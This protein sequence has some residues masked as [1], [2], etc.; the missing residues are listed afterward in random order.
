MAHWTKAFKRYERHFLLGLVIVLLATFSV[1]GA[2]T[3]CAGSMPPTVESELGGSFQLV[4]EPG[5]VAISDEDMQRLL[6]IF[7]QYM[8][9]VRMP[10]IDYASY[11]RGSQSP[12]MR[13]VAWMHALLARAS[14][15]AGYRCGPAQLGRAI[16]SV[17][18]S[19][20]RTASLEVTPEAY[21]RFI[22]QVW[23]RSPADFE[24]VVRGVVLKDELLSCLVDP[25]RF[26]QTYAQAYEDWKASRERVD[27]RYLAVEA[28]SFADEVRA[29][30]STRRALAEAEQPLRSVVETVRRLRLAL[31]RARDYKDAKGEWPATLA[32]LAAKDVQNQR[33][34]LAENLVRDPWG[35]D[36][37]YT[38]G[39]G[40]PVL[41][42]H[43]PDGKEGTADDVGLDMQAQLE[44]H[45]AVGR[46]AEALVRWRSAG[47]PRAWPGSLEDLVRAPA[48]AAGGAAMP[49][50]SSVPQD[51]W[52][53]PLS[54]VLGTG[55]ASGDEP[56]RLASA[57]PDGVAGT[58]DDIVAV[59]T[60]ERGRV[61][62]GPV[63]A[64]YLPAGRT[65][66]W[67]RAVTVSLANAEQGVYEASSVG[68]DGQPGTA[69]DLRGGNASDLEAFYAQPAVR[70]AFQQPM[71]RRFEALVMHLPLVSEAT[72]KRLWEDCPEQRVGPQDEQALFDRWQSGRGT[73]GSGYEFTAKDPRDPQDGHGMDLARK[74]GWPAQAVVRVPS[75]DCFPGLAAPPAPAE[76]AAPD[77]L[78]KEYEEQGWRE[79]LVRQEFLERVLNH[80]WKAVVAS[81][82]AIKAWEATAATSMAPRP[83]D[84]VTLVD[85]LSEERLGKYQP[86]EAERARGH[87]FL[88]YYTT[89]KADKTAVSLTRAEISAV[90]GLDELPLYLG[91]QRDGDVA[92]I[93]IQLN[94]RLTKVVAR[95][96]QLTAERIP[97]LAEV[98]DQ[99]FERWLERRQLDR[100]ERELAAFQRD[101]LQAPVVAE[102]QADT[103]WEAALEAWKKARPG[104]VVH[105]ERTGLFIGSSVPTQAR[106]APGASALEQAQ[107]LRRNFV[108]QGGYGLVRRGEAK[109]DTTDASPG[110]FGRATLRDEK[111]APDGT[112]CAF[113]VRVAERVYPTKAEFSPRAYSEYMS[114]RVFGAQRD[115]P[116]GM[117]MPV[118][119]RDG[120]MN[121]K[122]A[123][124]LEEFE[125]LQPLF[126]LR[127]NTNLDGPPVR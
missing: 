87:R 123:T 65:D 64:A 121:G 28:S 96:L 120:A 119:S 29:E 113:L 6:M 89:D 74:L 116:R 19:N 122:V 49:A 1:A 79:I 14:E 76:G 7:Q 4:G 84:G 58:P 63:L 38:L 75:R 48:R 107:L 36:L 27:L 61:A 56:P 73:A 57:G 68:A 62:L 45:K 12:A 3:Q 26:D 81:R 43:G 47:D 124:F 105:D 40:D 30:E 9:T 100:A 94:Q 112:G 103:R 37:R 41:G 18:A 118:G 72:L 93:P 108:R 42:S 86:G 88:E 33:W 11:L 66:A 67:G 44:T 99:V 101:V 31:N 25:V 5:R 16:K 90:P 71:R 70:S 17:L 126:D 92:S 80:H 78:R 21:E 106:P 102:G 50:L 8:A 20:E 46:V 59:L 51:G 91:N 32:V 117:R 39:T 13:K 111:R 53:R 10:T 115:L 52:N 85:L 54:Y 22:A 60:A 23:G 110:T 104:A 114:R 15:Q 35:K 82:E 97:D 55:G 127:T 24:Q 69:D 83:A 77:P 125:R 109:N 98:Q 95:T 2:V 34:A